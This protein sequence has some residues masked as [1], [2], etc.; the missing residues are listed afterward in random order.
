MNER[1]KKFCELYA[2]SPNATTA[3]LQAGYSEKTAYSIGNRLLKNVEVQNYLKE[4]QGAAS[5]ARIAQASEVKEIWSDILR[6]SKESTSNRLRAGELL[7][8]SCGEFAKSAANNANNGGKDA[9]TEETVSLSNILDSE[10]DRGEP[11][12]RPRG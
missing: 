6:N 1:Q 9:E 4:M 10:L 11:G 12:E 3:A 8:R 7:A 5:S 2:K